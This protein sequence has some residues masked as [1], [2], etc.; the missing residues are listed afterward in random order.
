[1]SCTASTTP[2]PYVVATSTINSFT[3]DTYNITQFICYSV[4]LHTIDYNCYSSIV[5]D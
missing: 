1:M 5:V 2:P 4:F 3:V